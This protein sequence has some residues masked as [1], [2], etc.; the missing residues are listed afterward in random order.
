[1]PLLEVHKLTMRFGGLTAVSDVD[2]DVPK[3][4]IFS[5]IGPNG[6]GKTTVFN[7]ITGIYDPTA[8]TIRCG[9]SDLRRPLTWRVVLACLAIGIFTSIAALLLALDIDQLWRAMIVR[10]M[11]DPEQPFSSAASL[12]RFPRL[13]ERSLG[14]RAV[15]ERQVGRRAL[16][17][18]AADSRL[19]RADRDDAPAD[20]RPGSTMSLPETPR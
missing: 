2:L 17:R 6:A 8:G 11:Q 5:V 4:S 10:N 14:G 1:M 13:H 16:E 20:R 3:D 9:G 18:V 15:A 19:W 7:A 12:G